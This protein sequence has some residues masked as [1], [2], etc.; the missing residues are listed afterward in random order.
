MH[1]SSHPSVQGAYCLDIGFRHMFSALDCVAFDWCK[2]YGVKFTPCV[3]TDARPGVES[4]V[5]REF[6]QSLGA[7]LLVSVLRAVGRFSIYFKF[8]LL[9][10]I[11]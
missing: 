9:L 4:L 7:R 6:T 11:K 10:A 1:L 8:A 3:Y 2:H 5:D